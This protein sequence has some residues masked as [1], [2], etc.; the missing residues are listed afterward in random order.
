VEIF[1]QIG[2]VKDRFYPRLVWNSEVKAKL[3]RNSWRVGCKKGKEAGKRQA[4]EKRE[5]RRKNLNFV[6]I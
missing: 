6:F 4:A 2:G 1:W 3:H 5:Q